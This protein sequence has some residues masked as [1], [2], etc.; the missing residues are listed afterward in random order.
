MGLKGGGNTQFS[1]LGVKAALER[2]KLKPSVARGDGS[3]CL[4]FVRLLCQ[5][6]I[7]ME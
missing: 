3:F 6:T 1:K 5:T 7:N 2:V 4:S